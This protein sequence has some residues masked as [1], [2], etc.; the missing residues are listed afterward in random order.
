MEDGFVCVYASFL[1][2]DFTTNPNIIPFLQNPKKRSLFAE[3]IPKGFYVIQQCSPYS[4]AGFLLV[5]AT[6]ADPGI[7][8]G[9]GDTCRLGRIYIYIHTYVCVPIGDILSQLKGLV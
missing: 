5:S 9:S 4:I 1:N 8:Q 2:G 3:K 6:L 7:T